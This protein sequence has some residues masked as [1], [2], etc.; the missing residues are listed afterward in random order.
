M[1]ENKYLRSFLLNA[2]R[3]GKI[4][5]LTFRHKELDSIRGLAALLVVIHHT[6]F[7]IRDH[8]SWLEYTPVRLAIA[9]RPCV[10]IFFVLSGFV[11]CSSIYNTARFVLSK[12]Y[13]KR[14]IRIYLPTAVSILLAAGANFYLDH[15]DRPRLGTWF[16]E[17]TPATDTSFNMV[18][19]HLLLYG[20]KESV[21][22]NNPLWSIVIELRISLLFPVIFFAAAHRFYF[23]ILLFS[24]MIFNSLVLY[25]EFL[26]RMPF[27]ADSLVQ[28]VVLTVYFIPFFGLGAWLFHNIN[29]LTKMYYRLDRCQKSLIWISCFILLSI[30]RDLCSAVGALLLVGLTLSSEKAKKALNFRV[31]EWLG[32]ISF[33]LYLV[34]VIVL[35]L[36]V[37]LFYGILDDLCLTFI[38]MITSLGVAQLYYILI[39]RTSIILGSFLAGKF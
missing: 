14:I 1:I 17:Y 38:I 13:I 25:F 19:S 9:G 35:M 27:V 23:V 28:N 21:V 3:P 4:D 7:I 11:L 22:L 39:E 15:V 5:L 30:N 33:S 32:Q 34:H 31:F 36:A 29:L 12:F 26:P 24:L 8:Y 37:H 18:V 20:T 16:K 6:F 10:I 2:C